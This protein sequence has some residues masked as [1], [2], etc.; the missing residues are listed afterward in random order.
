M[1]TDEY[2]RE[3]D[4]VSAFLKDRTVKKSGKRIAK[5][6]MYEEFLKYCDENGYESIG[7][8]NFGSTL[9]DKD[10]PEGKSDSVR[11]WK[12]ITF[13]KDLDFDE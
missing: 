1:A 13:I 11:Y 9:L 12:D 8:N 3:Q 6:A 7:K 5:A 4:A 2:R 10:M